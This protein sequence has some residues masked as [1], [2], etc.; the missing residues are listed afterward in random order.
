MNNK[1]PVCGWFSLVS[2][3]VGNAL[4]ISLPAAQSRKGGGKK[5]KIQKGTIGLRKGRALL[6]SCLSLWFKVSMSILP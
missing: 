2:C 3:S 5:E 4:I 1:K 6:E